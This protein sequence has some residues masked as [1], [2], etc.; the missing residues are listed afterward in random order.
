MLA[1]FHQGMLLFLPL[2]AIGETPAIIGTKIDTEY[3]NGYRYMEASIDVY[4]SS[5][6][7]HIVSLVRKKC[8]DCCC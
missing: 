4:S 2:Q 8:D 7:R 3:Y 6:A 5:L 1:D